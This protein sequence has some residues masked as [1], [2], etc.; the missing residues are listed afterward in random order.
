MTWFSKRI[1]VNQSEQLNS[2]CLLV[3]N[4]NVALSH[5]ALLPNSLFCRLGHRHLLTFSSAE[6][7]THRSHLQALCFCLLRY[8]V[9]D[10]LQDC[11]LL[12]C[13]V[14]LLLQ[15]TG[16]RVPEGHAPKIWPITV[17]IIIINSYSYR[18]AS[19]R[20][21]FLLAKETNKKIEN[22]KYGS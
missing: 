22:A 16:P 5:Q 6:M 17:I 8:R 19:K 21:K 3:W 12:P 13:R 20:F 4:W 18:L 2:R 14:H 9:S 1:T 15:L 10:S 7:S 11:L